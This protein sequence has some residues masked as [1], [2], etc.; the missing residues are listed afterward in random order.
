VYQIIGKGGKFSL[1]GAAKDTNDTVKIFGKNIN[2]IRKNT[3]LLQANR[4]VSQEINGE[5]MKFVVVSYHHNPGQNHNLLIVNT[6]FETVEKLKYL[7]TTVTN[8]NN[9]HQEIKGRL[10]SGNA[11]YPSVQNLLSCLLSK[12]LNIKIY[13]TTVLSGV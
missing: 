6:S 10:N 12:N 8:Q 7:G 9:I 5:K 3:G 11:C 2:T 1:L 13:K 4:K